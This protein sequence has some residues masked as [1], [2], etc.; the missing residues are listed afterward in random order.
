MRPELWPLP[1]IS[2][3][4]RPLEISTRENPVHCFR[5]F[6]SSAASLWLSAYPLFAQS[7]VEE[8]GPLPLHLDSEQWALLETLQPAIT[9]FLVLPEGT[10]VSLELLTLVTTRTA[11]RKDRVKFQVVSDVSVEGLTVIPKGSVAWG[12]VTLVKKPG[13]FERDGKLQIEVNS[14]ILL[15]GQ[16]IA[17]RKPPPPRPRGG[18][19]DLRGDGLQIPLLIPVAAAIFAVS[20]REDQETIL[21]SILEDVFTKGHH[22][23]L[24]PGTPVEAEVSQALELNREEFGKLQS[25]AK[26]QV[27]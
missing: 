18:G 17:I 7:P 15:N 16:T 13:R 26:G 3:T 9:E 11:K 6:L 19:W 21:G 20:P 24:L 5:H 23:E 12:T 2:L 27:P 4:H 14:V 8:I 1:C 10:P 25:V 22:A